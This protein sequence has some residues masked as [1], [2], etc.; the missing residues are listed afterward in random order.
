MTT[1]R[2]EEIKNKLY[3]TSWKDEDAEEQAVLISDAY[4]ALTQAHQAGIDEAVEIVKEW[5][6]ENKDLTT[7]FGSNQAHWYIE[8]EALDDTIKALQDKK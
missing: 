2:I 6:Q 3:S 8:V 4:Q 1:P 5:V 7:I